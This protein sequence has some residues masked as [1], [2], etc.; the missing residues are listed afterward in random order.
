M[1]KAYEVKVQFEDDKD[2]CRS[3]SRRIIAST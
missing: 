2:E 1:M 3:Y